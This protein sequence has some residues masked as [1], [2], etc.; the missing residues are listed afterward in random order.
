VSI[1]WGG[2][3]LMR[4]VDVSITLVLT[5]VAPA[6]AQSAKHQPVF[7]FGEGLASCGEFL[8]KS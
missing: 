4:F 8:Q 6:L 1:K 5:L 7:I 3:S 2:D